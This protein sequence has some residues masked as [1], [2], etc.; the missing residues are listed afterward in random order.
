ML[1][2]LKNPYSDELM[3]GLSQDIYNL[4]LS[5]KY[6][7]RKGRDEVI[8]SSRKVENLDEADEYSNNYSIYT[9]GGRSKTDVITF[10]LKNIEPYTIGGIENSFNLA[11]TYSNTKQNKEDYN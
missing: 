9:N 2:K 4:N 7:H 10:D 5:G 6:I 1:S 11:F 3:I 8:L